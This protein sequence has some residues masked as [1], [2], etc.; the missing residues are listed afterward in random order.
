MFGKMKRKNEMNYTINSQSQNIKIV[1][2]S[3]QNP[4]HK[5]PY[6]QALIL[7]QKNEEQ[8]RRKQEIIDQILEKNQR[9]QK[10]TKLK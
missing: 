7:S 6:R 2:N 3:H 10:I 8:E 9:V 1:H 4:G 5:L